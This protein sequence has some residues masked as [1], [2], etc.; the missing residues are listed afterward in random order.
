M[1]FR[2]LATTGCPRHCPGPHPSLQP[3]TWHLFENSFATR[4]VAFG[5]GGG[6][7]VKAVR[8]QCRW[9]KDSK[10]TTETSSAAS[11]LCNTR[12]TRPLRGQARHTVH[13]LSGKQKIEHNTGGCCPGASPTGCAVASC[14][15]PGGVRWHRKEWWLWD[16]WVGGLR[17]TA[18]WARRAVCS[19]PAPLNDRHDSVLTLKSTCN[20]P[21]P[22]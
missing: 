3:S 21:W 9:P 16:L 18:A 4:R 6:G 12:H 2:L 13:P 7:R 22:V 11:H 17:P 19:R 10:T 5:L 15:V 20:E 8:C 1:L 14:I